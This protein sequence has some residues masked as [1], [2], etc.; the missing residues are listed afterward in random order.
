MLSL[1]KIIIVIVGLGL[2]IGCS[3]TKRLKN[4]PIGLINNVSYVNASF[5]NPNASNGFLVQYKDDTY[6]VTAKHILVMAKTDKMKFV[7]FEGELKEWKMHPKND[8]TKYVIIENLLNANKKD[9][10]TWSYMDTNWDNYNDWLVFSIKENK[11]NY[12]PLIFRETSLIKGEDLYVIGW[13]YKDTIGSQRLYQ[14]K[15]DEIDGN[16]YNLKQ[17]NGPQGLGGLS[18]SPV[19]DKKGNVVGLVSSGWEDEKTNE[20]FIQATKID[21]AFKFISKLD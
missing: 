8:S 2:L 9:S 3:S 11:T 19:V 10:L 15:F 20:V 14:Y 5:N 17:V 16:Y 1:Q 13:S 6:A 12:K 7:D 18:G 21:N 4:T